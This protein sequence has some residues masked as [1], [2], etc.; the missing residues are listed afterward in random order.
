MRRLCDGT[1]GDS[2]NG[3]VVT[4][5][6]TTLRELAEQWTDGEL[7]DRYPDHV[8]KKRSASDDRWR[9][10]KHIFPTVGGVAL[11][12]FTLEHAEHVMQRL[13][14]KLWPASRRQI[15]QLMHRLLAMPVY[16]CRIVKVSPIP[17]G[18]LPSPGGKKA[19]PI[20]YP[21]EDAQLLAC[22]DIPLDY[23]IYGFLHRDGM[24]R[25]EAVGLTWRDID[26][27][28]GVVRLDESKTDHPRWWRMSPGVPEA[29][30]A[31]WR[32]RSEPAARPAGWIA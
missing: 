30:K 19:Y 26:L 9:F 20:L 2:P 5:P 15:A 23:R 7:H 27:E 13:P 8:K 29:L 11:S 3:A 28:H 21:R 18:W 12:D 31:W 6:R 4:A 1:Y 32:L 16:P 17:R 10:E 25:S 24:R 22:P 14:R